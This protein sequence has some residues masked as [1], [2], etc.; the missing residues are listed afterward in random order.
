MPWLCPLP[1][2]VLRPILTSS[3]DSIILVVVLSLRHIHITEDMNEEKVYLSAKRLAQLQKELAELK[4]IKRKEVARRIAEAKELGDLSENA[5]YAEAKN[6]QAFIEG[7]ILELENIIKNATLIE[8]AKQGNKDTVSVGSTITIK[9]TDGEKTYSIVG[10]NEAE[11][12]AGK[13]SNVSPLG[14]AF[15][16][17]RVG[18]TVSIVVPRGKLQ[19]TITA[20]K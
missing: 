20:V 12:V 7:R 6:E 10:S 17:R 3:L 14:R 15:L 2:L 16:G 18:E 11:P 8:E 13:I 4:T 5:E 19:V 1:V 9:S